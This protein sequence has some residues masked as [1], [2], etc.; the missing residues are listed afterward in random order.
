M[1]EVRIQFSGTPVFEGLQSGDAVELEEGTTVAEL[2]TRFGVK[3]SFQ[4]Y[5]IP[6]VNED[7]RDLDY[8][9]QDGDVL[10]PFVPVS[11]G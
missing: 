5:V 6:Y 3:E 10:R 2:F 1:I 4:Q 7:P 8:V 9:F 11:G